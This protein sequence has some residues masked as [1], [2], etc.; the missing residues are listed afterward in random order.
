V[1]RVRLD[2]RFTYKPGQAAQ[3]G[4]AAGSVLVPYSIASA[5]ED[6]GRDGCL[7]FLI[8]IDSGG[9]WGENSGSS[10]SPGERACRRSAP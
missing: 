7:E 9:R 6:T 2:D 5:P 4:P 3:I 8:R 1:V 10:S